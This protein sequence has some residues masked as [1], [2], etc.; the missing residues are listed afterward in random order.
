MHGEE[1]VETDQDVL[2]FQSERARV[3]L[4]L[5]L[6]RRFSEVSVLAEESHA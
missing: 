6:L 3:H 1:A 4:G 2:H 5:D